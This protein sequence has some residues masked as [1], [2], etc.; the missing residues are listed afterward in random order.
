MAINTDK[1]KVMI[2]ISKKVTYVNFVYDIRNLEKVTY[3]KYIG[4]DI[5]HKL[6]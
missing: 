5:H 1:P 2:I 4:I 3:Y 6:N